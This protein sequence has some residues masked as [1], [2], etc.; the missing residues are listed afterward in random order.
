M[1]A[2]WRPEYKRDYAI[3]DGREAA[4]FSIFRRASEVRCSVLIKFLRHKQGQ[5]VCMPW[6]SVLR[7]GHDLAALLRFF[8]RK[9]S[10]LLSE[11]L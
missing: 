3:N 8:D 9:A 1:A 5:Y 10:T 4:G 6:I 11:C 2:W 7:R